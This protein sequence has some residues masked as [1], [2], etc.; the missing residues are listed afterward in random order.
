ME[1]IAE[2][3]SSIDIDKLDDFYQY[4]TPL[5]GQYLDRKASSNINF[6]FLLLEIN[7]TAP[8]T[9][10]ILKIAYSLTENRLYKTEVINLIKYRTKFI[11]ENGFYTL[12]LEQLNIFPKDML[13]FKIKLLNDRDINTKAKLFFKSSFELRD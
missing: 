1:K 12:N 6:D 13:Y 8:P 11:F 4:E 3:Y 2:I 9:D 10:C 5:E 7:T